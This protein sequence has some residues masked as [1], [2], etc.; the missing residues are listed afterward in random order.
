MK[1][2]SKV[3]DPRR[4]DEL[5]C[6]SAPADPGESVL[7]GVAE[8]VSGA[9]RIVSTSRPE[10][11]TQDILDAAA[12]LEPT[13]LFRFAGKCRDAC[14]HFQN[15]ECRIATGSVQLL[16]EV[17]SELPH[18]SIRKHCRWFR[19]EG[20]A[21]CRRCPQVLTQQVKPTERVRRIVEHD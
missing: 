19:Q 20:A 6:P 11:V 5:L 7:I 2:D 13:Q 8:V 21:I 15:D 18:C 16:D 9:L 1:S 4:D 3:G 17:V 10:P 12:P 14:I